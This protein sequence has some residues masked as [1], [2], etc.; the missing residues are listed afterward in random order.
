MPGVFPQSHVRSFASSSGYSTG[1]LIFISSFKVKTKV[2]MA[3]ILF[4]MIEIKQFPPFLG[5]FIQNVMSP[6]NEA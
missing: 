5:C 4:R 1:S 3:A 2:H 6:L